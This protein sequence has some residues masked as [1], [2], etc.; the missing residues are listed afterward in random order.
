MLQSGSGYVVLKLVIAFPL[1]SYKSV[2]TKFSNNA[3]YHPFFQYLMNK[4]YKFFR[5]LLEVVKKDLLMSP[6]D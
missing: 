4:E 3:L 2:L 6:R 5:G 1:L